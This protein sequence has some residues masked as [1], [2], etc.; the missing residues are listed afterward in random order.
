MNYIPRL[1]QGQIA[2][3]IIDLG[4]NGILEKFV[5]KCEFAFDHGENC[6]LMKIK[7]FSLS[8]ICGNNE[9]F[10]SDEQIAECLKI[11]E[12][13]KYLNFTLQ[14]DGDFIVIKYLYCNQNESEYVPKTTHIPLGTFLMGIRSANKCLKEA[15][16]N[17]ALK[18]EVTMTEAWRLFPIPDN[19]Q[20]V[21]VSNTLEKDTA[22]L[23][24][25][26]K[27]ALWE[28]MNDNEPDEVPDLTDLDYDGTISEYIDGTVPIHYNEI[29]DFWYLHS[30]RLEEAYENAGVGDNPRASNGMAAIYCLY[31]EI[32]YEWYE[33]YK[34][35]IFDE[36]R[37]KNSIQQM[38]DALNS[39]QFV[40]ALA[41]YC[42][43]HCDDRNYIAP[44]HLTILTSMQERIDAFET[45]LVGN[46][47]EEGFLHNFVTNNWAF[48]DENPDV[49]IKNKEYPVCIRPLDT[50]DEWG[51][52]LW[53]NATT[54]RWE[55]NYSLELE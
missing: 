37:V 17:Y 28:W 31:E 43:E 13:G 30:N 32:L 1:S 29:D 5:V 26:V 18:M 36:W 40:S 53:F 41:D 25:T 3:N 45:F 23:I 48:E 34:E 8:A 6:N 44:Y 35:E 11:E 7:L 38:L 15:I 55:A 22:T 21:E 14:Q 27:E 10:I 33:G 52:E 12:E 39:N 9:K 49:F 4:I 47:D 24:E 2:Q 16:N 54:E 50:Y 19:K 20:V 46:E 51:F 42:G